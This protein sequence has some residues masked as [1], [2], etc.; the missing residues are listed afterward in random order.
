MPVESRRDLLQSI[1]EEGERLSRFVGNLLDMTRIEAGALEAKHDWVDLNDVI[2]DSIARA[3]RV[4]PGTEISASIAKDLPLLRADSL[5]LGQ[6]LF[7]LIDNA[8]KH[9]GGEPVTVYARADDT[10]LSLSVTDM[11]KGIS[12]KDIDRIFESSTVAARERMAASRGPALALPLPRA[13]S[14]RWAARSPSKARR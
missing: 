12:E 6:V 10:I 1:E 13:L 2:S 8:C 7:N 14:R 11:G 3:R 5:L 4:A 9:G